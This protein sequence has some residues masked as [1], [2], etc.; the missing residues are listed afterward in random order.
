MINLTLTGNEHHVRILILALGVLW[1][2]QA[3]AAD[4]E[5]P[6]GRPNIVIFLTDDQGWGDLGYHGNPYVKTPKMDA[7]CSEAIQLNRFHVS[8]VCSPTRASLMTGR[9]N[10]RTGV[11]SVAGGCDMDPQEVTLAE[12]LKAAGYATGIFGKWH[13]GDEGPHR[14]NAQGFDEAMVFKMGAM[15]PDMYF[16]PTFLHN[17]VATK[18]KGY[19]MDVY[20][21]AAIAFMRQNKSKPFFLYLPTNLIH[22][23]LKVAEELEATFRAA[24][25][26]RKTA[27]ISGMLTSIDNNF[28]RLRAALKELG[29]EDNTLL[30]FMSDNGPCSGSIQMDRFM[31]GQ[32]G[33][34]GTVY[35]NGIHVPCYVRWPARL[36]SP[37]KVNRLTAHIDIMPTVLEACGVPAP[38]GAK[39]DG[40]SMLPL[41]RNASASWPNRT[42]FFQWDSKSVPRHGRCFTAIDERW[43]LVQPVGIDNGTQMHI[44]QRYSE[45]CKVQKRGER[46]IVGEPRYELYDLAAD[47]GEWKDLASA[48]PEVVERMKKQYDAWFN[49]V[50]VRWLEKAD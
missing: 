25:L 1:P 50:A 27:A 5:K 28:G 4:M 21:N 24:G 14:P 45:L 17:D 39:L 22:T 46:A 11:S 48:H 20:T 9:Y 23:P 10:F 12:T 35:E 37:A 38:S 34:K 8:P 29:I 42:L 7:F 44:C 32:H 18:Y 41:L 15:S 47:P 13:L 33:L 40:I 2:L 36:K 43:K 16:D 49:E 19:C 26:E 6:Q 3:L 30:I 31:A